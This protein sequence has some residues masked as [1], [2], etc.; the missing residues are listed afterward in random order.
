[1]KAEVAIEPIIACETVDFVKASVP[2]PTEEPEEPTEEE[3]AIAE[4]K[5]EH[6]VYAEPLISA[7]TIAVFEASVPEPSDEPESPTVEE[8]H[9]AEPQTV[10]E[11][12]DEPTR[13]VNI[14]EASA[15]G[16]SDEPEEPTE[17]EAIIEQ[18]IESE[19]G[20]EM[21]AEPVAD[22]DEESKQVS[23]DV[24]DGRTPTA[25]A[26]PNELSEEE[27]GIEEPVGEGVDEV[28][29]AGP[30]KP[31]EVDEEQDMQ[32]SGG[33]HTT[34]EEA[35]EQCQTDVP[36][37]DVPE[38]SVDETQDDDDNE[39]PPAETEEKDFVKTS[40]SFEDDNDATPK[41]ATP[42]NVDTL[43]EVMNEMIFDEPEN[44]PV[45]HEEPGE[46][47]EEKFDQDLIEYQ[48]EQPIFVD[49]DADKA[50]E[51]SDHEDVSAAELDD[52]L[53]RDF[54]A[55]AGLPET[56]TSEYTEDSI[57]TKSTTV[58][59]SSWGN[60]PKGL[61]PFDPFEEHFTEEHVDICD[62]PD[63][64]TTT[65]V[66]KKT[67]VKTSMGEVPDDFEIGDGDEVEERVNEDGSVT[68]VIRRVRQISG[69][70]GDPE[71]SQ[72]MST[73]DGADG[74]IGETDSKRVVVHKKVTKKIVIRDGEEVE[75]EEST[76][77]KIEE[78]GQEVQDPSE[79]RE[80]LQQMIDSF[81][82]EEQM[83]EQEKE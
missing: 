31:F 1:M 68:R 37:E 33:I 54:T 60:P 7:E 3:V 2:Q 63:R 40:E 39:V 24:I 13:T 67:V 10:E 34:E 58:K 71:F 22:F 69:S 82:T 80:D 73:N 9:I 53:Q 35:E 66:I 51:V 79:L 59:S 65:K 50:D 81:L 62:E 28:E 12:L 48:Q 4:P 18:P 45:E 23:M 21:K 30:S 74:L 29:G 20:F 52:L 36:N 14:L 27:A 76:D 41:D 16:P 8:E 83:Q 77:T 46:I 6:G 38:D 78:D 44:T 56:E 32:S 15:P 17:E 5:K 47:V 70:S 25:S 55:E 57:T 43:A 26:E 61:D 75:V 64:R 11:N 49:G 42:E 72:L 19:F